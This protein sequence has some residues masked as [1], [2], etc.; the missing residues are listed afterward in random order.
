MIR[1]NVEKNAAPSITASNH[2]EQGKRVPVHGHSEEHG[3]E[4][5]DESLR[6]AAQ[7]RR[8]RLAQDERGSRRGAHEELVQD[9]QVPLPDDR[10]AVEDRDK[11]HALGQDPGRHE[12]D[13][14]HAPRG[15][16]AHAGE[17]LA[18]DKEPECRLYCA[19]EQLG[20]VMEKLPRLHPGD[21]ESP[22]RRSAGAR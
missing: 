3:Q 1:E 21:G 8:N 17:D 4:V 5:D 13:V 12:I 2:P 19:G 11:E 16:G 14:A 20:R 6:Q 9:P 15:D 22:S 7:A 10:D 18:E